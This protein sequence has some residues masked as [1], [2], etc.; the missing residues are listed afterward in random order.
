MLSLELTP[1]E[2]RALSEILADLSQRAKYEVSLDR[3]L[4]NWVRFV[5][6]VEQGY[7]DSIY[8]YTND[9]SNRDTLEEI[10]RGRSFP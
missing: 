8:E 3:L 2:S 9:L 5:D 6:E 10:S 7:Q 4:S 1:D